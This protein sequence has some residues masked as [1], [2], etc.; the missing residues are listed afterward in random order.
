MA[1]AATAAAPQSSGG[2][3]PGGSGAGQNPFQICTNLYAEKNLQGLQTAL[4]TTTSAQQLGGQVNAGQ[5]L[6]GVHFI[7]RN[8]NTPAT[9]STV[10]GRTI[11]TQT[12]G[13]MDVIQ[14]MDLINVD[15]S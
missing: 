3:A 5:F 7:V 8:T 2:G 11:T 10:N 15:G 13:A 9:I 12:D 14:N 6:R 1:A 4:A